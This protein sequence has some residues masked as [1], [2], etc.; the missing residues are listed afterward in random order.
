[1]QLLG[2]VCDNA[3]NNA[4]MI[5]KLESLLE[6]FLGSGVRVRCFAHTLNLI[7]KVS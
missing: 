4:T 1:M 7:V 2:V 5:D 3:E 6:K